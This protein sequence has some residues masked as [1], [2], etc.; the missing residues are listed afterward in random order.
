MNGGMI[1]CPPVLM[2]QRDPRWADKILGYNAA[3]TSFTIG[4]Y[5]C[6]LTCLSSLCAMTP[7]S[8][9]EAGKARNLFSSGGGDA[10]TFDPQLWAPGAPYELHGVSLRYSDA[11]FPHGAYSQLIQHVEE[12]G[13]AICEVQWPRTRGQHFVLAIA[14]PPVDDRPCLLIADPERAGQVEELSAYYGPWATALVRTV[15]Y[16]PVDEVPSAGGAGSSG[17]ALAK[18]STNQRQSEVLLA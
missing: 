1:G 6:L 17:A 15:L 3:G 10:L 11:P 9:N 13:P 7:Q 2:R 12:V 4:N 5:G 18:I 16:R 8:L 14:A